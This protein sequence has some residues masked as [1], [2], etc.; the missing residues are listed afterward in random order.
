MLSS[1]HVL[2]RYNMKNIKLLIILVVLIVIAGIYFFS[3]S[4][5]SLN[6]RNSSF[7]IELPEDI[8]KIQISTPDEK[9]V[10]EKKNDYW[11]VNN[12]Y[13]ATGRNIK[14][15]MMAIRLIEVLSPVSKVEKEQITSILKADGIIVEI[16]KKNRTLKKY[17]V[18]KPE[19]NN[20]KTY[21][22]MYKSSEPFVVRIPSFKGLVADI[23][24][25]DENFWRD[26]TIFNYQPQNIK[27]ISVEYPENPSK[28]FRVIN[29]ND[30]TFA[31]Q[32]IIDDTFVEDFNIDKVARYFTYFQ[33]I[34]FEDMVSNL[35]QTEVNSILQTK[36]FNII[37]V[38]NI[39]GNKNKITIYRKPPEK[40]FDEFGQK[41]LFD[42]DRAYATFNNNNEL[43]IIQYYIFDP[44][45]KE[46]DYFR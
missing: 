24:I 3:N 42:Y 12:K 14:N 32:N 25:I 5:G 30:G 36:P 40:E 29:Y 37:T 22:M 1:K 46:I 13:R 39:Q 41:V 35:N 16:F 34:V 44:L 2:K 43:I 31:I 17:Y 6:L 4:K 23:F 33:R 28:S 7:A 27:N 45:F 8:T 26:K 9:L 20:S 18:S 11:K 10:L 19:M 21:M 15:F 38:E